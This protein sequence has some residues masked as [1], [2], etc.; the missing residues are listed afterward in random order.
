[1]KFKFEVGDVVRNKEFGEKQKITFR[2]KRRGKKKALI[3]RKV[4]RLGSTNHYE[5][6][7]I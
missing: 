2:T 5:D 4:E 6:R 3:F 1:M 7:Y